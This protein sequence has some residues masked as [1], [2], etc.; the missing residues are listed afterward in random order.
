MAIEL[1]NGMRDTDDFVTTNNVRYTWRPENWREAILRLY[2]NGMAPLT[3]IMSMVG[4][5][6]TDD[7]I[8]H[9]FDKDLPTLRAAITGQWDNAAM[10]TT[11]SDDVAA[12]GTV[13]IQMS[14]LDAQQFKVGHLVELRD[15]TEL[16][17]LKKMVCLVTAVTLAA[18]SSYLTLKALEA[19]PATSSGV[20]DVAYII[21]TAY[22]EGSDTPAAVSYNP[23]QYYNYTQIFRTSLQAT[24]TAKKTRLR[25]GDYMAEAKRE[26]LELHSIELERALLFGVR[27]ATTGTLGYPLRTT[28]GIMR[29]ISTNSFNFAVETSKTS[30]ATSGEA[31]LDE[32]LEQTFRYGSNQKLALCGSGA[33]LGI[34]KLVKAKGTF[35]FTEKTMGYGIQVVQ[36]TTPFGVINIKT[37]PLFNQEATL[38]NTMLVLEPKNIIPRIITDTNYLPNRQGNGLDSELSEFLTEIGYEYHFEKA[39]AVFRGVG[40][41]PAS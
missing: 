30:W 13:Y 4:S 39:F 2:P 31:W 32:K 5:K 21:G 19:D 14:L 7:P 38:A 20:F 26:A 33:L 22:E 23:N 34:N 9:W 40:S 8:F 28:M 27:Y 18:A 6:P 37:H 24:R 29:F 15:A 12:A 1:L 36:W 41:A 17:A 11:Y 35:Q 25:T 3:A 10:T 16:Y